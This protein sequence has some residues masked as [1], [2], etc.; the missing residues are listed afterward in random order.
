MPDISVVIPTFRRPELL[1]ETI[2]SVLAQPEVTSEIIVVDD[3]PDGS[4]APVAASFADRGVAYHRTTAPSG[5]RPALVRNAGLQHATADIVHFLDDDDLVPDG[6]YPAALDLF[7]RNRQVG[8]VFGRI[9]PFGEQDV[10]AETGYFDTAYRNARFLAHFGTRLGFSASMVFRS[11]L[12]ICSA[13]MIRRQ[14]AQALGGFDPNP[15]LAED[16]EFYARAI[17]R[18]GAV[19]ADRTSIRY[20]IGPSLMRSERQLDERQQLISAAYRSFQ[21]RYHRDH[22]VLD[23]SALKVFAHL[24]GAVHAVR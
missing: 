12:I 5:G 15:L 17:R 1:A 9:E 21:R 19:V 11:T 6:Y 3:C 7:R 18:F 16:V 22:G 20:R 13:A 2:A 8:V 10:A 4:A 14:S 23:Y 24:L